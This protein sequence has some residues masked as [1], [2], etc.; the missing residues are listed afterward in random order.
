MRWLLTAFCYCL[1]FSC[2]AQSTNLRPNRAA[3]ELTVAV[4]SAVAYV[5]TIQAGPFVV[6]PNILQIYPDETVFVEV[7]VKKGRIITLTPVQENKR[8]DRTREISFTQKAKGRQ[9]EMMMLKLVNP[10]NKTLIYSAMIYLL[11]ERKF[12]P[13]SVLPVEAGLTT[14]ETWPDIITTLALTGWK[15]R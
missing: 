2:L 11:Q 13:T 6:G 10:F 1:A 5:D 15:F 7:E 3:Y 12:V 4:D 8:P 14:F 9:H